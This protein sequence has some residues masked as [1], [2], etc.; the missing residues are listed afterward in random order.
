MSIDTSSLAGVWQIFGGLTPV[1]RT[2]HGP[3][4]TFG[5]PEPPSFGGLLNNSRSFGML[6]TEKAPLQKRQW[7]EPQDPTEKPSGSSMTGGSRTQFRV[8]DS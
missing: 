4:G 5:V 1:L 6:P 7:W 8:R 2:V 3:E